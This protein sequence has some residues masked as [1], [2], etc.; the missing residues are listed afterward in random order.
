MQIQETESKRIIDFIASRSQESITEQ[1]GYYRRVVLC[2][3]HLTAPKIWVK[4]RSLTE[5]AI[6]S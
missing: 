3:S 2:V 1:G 5:K 6:I 4:S